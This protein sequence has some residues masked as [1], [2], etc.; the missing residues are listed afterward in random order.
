MSNLMRWEPAREMMTLREAMDRL[1]DDAFTR[2]RSVRDGWS[3]ASP[4]IDMYQTDNEVVVRASIPGIKADE[5]GLVVDG[6]VMARP[7]D[8]SSTSI[9]QP[10]PAMSRPP[11]IDSS[12]TVKP[13]RM[14]VRI[15]GSA[16]GMI[17]CANREPRSNSDPSVN[18]PPATIRI[19]MLMKAR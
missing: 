10:L 14:P 5:A 6:S 2:P 7:T 19:V 17:T 15:S 3:M 1:F 8:S 12:A 4:A 16:A 18:R 9:F 11:M 13:M